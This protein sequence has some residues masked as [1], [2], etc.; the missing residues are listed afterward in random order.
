MNEP[1]KDLSFEKIFSKGTSISRIIHFLEGDT[2][3]EVTDSKIRTLIEEIKAFIYNTPE[4]S[5][6]FS[7][8]IE[9]LK[10]DYPVN[11]RGGSHKRYR[12]S[13]KYRKYQS[14]KQSRRHIQR[15]KRTH[16]R[17]SRRSR[18]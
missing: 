6:S 4:Y 2:T 17:K 18:K 8:M 14:R 13:R 11:T 3:A 16:R 1:P 7:S 10:S 9:C 12:T 5:V 15:R